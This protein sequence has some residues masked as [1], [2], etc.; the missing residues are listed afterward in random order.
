MPTCDICGELSTDDHKCDRV[1][2]AAEIRALRAER[3][4]LLDR[5]ALGESLVNQLEDSIR[6]PIYP[7]TSSEARRQL[8]MWAAR[9]EKAK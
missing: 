9:A 1:R 6:L 7:I 2:M 5:L 3:E 8:S 4:R